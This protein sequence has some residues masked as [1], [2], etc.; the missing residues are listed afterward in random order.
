MNYKR[1]YV[2]ETYIAI[3]KKWFYSKAKSLNCI[4][5]FIVKMFICKI[6]NTVE[7]GIL[8]ISF[9]FGCT[10]HTL[11]DSLCTEQDFFWT[12]F[13]MMTQK[14]LKQGYVAPR[15]ESSLQKLYGRQHNVVDR[16]EI[17]IS[18]MTIDLLLFT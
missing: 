10:T 8:R 3:I 1:S 11:F 16:N 18:E 9:Q 5:L 7:S 17:S 15:L 2:I 4:R 12:E 14:L 6:Q 13:S